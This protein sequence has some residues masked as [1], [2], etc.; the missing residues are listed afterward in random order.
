MTQEEAFIQARMQSE[1]AKAIGNIAYAVKH[2]SG[3]WSVEIHKPFEKT[4]AQR[5]AESRAAEA[6]RPRR[7]AARREEEREYHEDRYADLKR[8]LRNAG[9]NPDDLRD[10]LA[11]PRSY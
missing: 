10:W 4:K 6:D 3:D 11:G 5:Q 2:S 1:A 8:S 7:E 9:I